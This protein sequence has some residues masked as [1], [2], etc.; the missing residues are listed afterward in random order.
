MGKL[1]GQSSFFRPGPPAKPGEAYKPIVDFLLHEVRG[2]SVMDLGGGEGAYA[3]E[4]S[5]AGYDVVVADINPESL[6]VAAEN[7]LNTCVLQAGESLGE[8]V[9]DT[10]MMIE[11]L[12]HVPD[13]KVFLQSA[14][15]A[16][17]KRVVF[18]LPCTED[19]DSLFELG[20]SYAHVAVS[21]HLWHFSFQEMKQI[22]DSLG[23]PYTLRMGDYLF[24][25]IS[26]ALMREHFR[27]P[28]GF[29][30]TLPVRIANR[31]GFVPKKIP[32]RFYGYI[33]VS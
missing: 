33:D 27:G 22:L 16:A 29:M 24:P 20:L 8:G 15:A 17:R 14:M 12:E 32:S 6:K 26:M 23:K 2:R 10:V 30:A 3:L 18:T 19:F 11:V 25:H 13:P 28:L 21:D 9:A 1:Q 7:G 5:C 4:L 31:L